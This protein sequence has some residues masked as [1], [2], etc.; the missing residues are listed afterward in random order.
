MNIV[1]K[2]KVEM[3]Y[4]KIGNRRIKL[5]EINVIKSILLFI[6]T[7]T[8]FFRFLNDVTEC[9]LPIG[10]CK[11]ICYHLIGGPASWLIGIGRILYFIMDLSI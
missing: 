9:N 1:S 5:L 3:L 4:L 8:G 2:I 11:N 6:W 7:A 10:I